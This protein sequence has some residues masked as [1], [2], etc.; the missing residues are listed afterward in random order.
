MKMQV[1][2]ERDAIDIQFDAIFA[3]LCQ[4][5]RGDF[6]RRIRRIDEL[7]ATEI[8]SEVLEA[9]NQLDFLIEDLRSFSARAVTE[10]Y[11]RARAELLSV[12]RQ[13]MRGDSLR[14]R[15]YLKLAEECCHEM[16]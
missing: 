6:R 3:A 1:C 12:W 5:S 2:G 8:D 10:V 13:I 16:D 4:R 11:R 14:A 7:L 15:Y 9:V